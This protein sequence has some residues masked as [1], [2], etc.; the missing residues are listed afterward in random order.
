MEEKKFRFVSKQIQQWSSTQVKRNRKVGNGVGQFQMFTRANALKCYL[1]H[2]HNFHLLFIWTIFMDGCV[3]QFTFFFGIQAKHTCGK[4]ALAA[5]DNIKYLNVFRHLAL[6][7]S[8]NELYD[9]GTM[10]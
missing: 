2:Q 10:S 4:D 6:S 9:R 1:R 7:E 5:L 3:Q 8:V